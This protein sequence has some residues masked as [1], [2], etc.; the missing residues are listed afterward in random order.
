MWLARAF[1]GKLWL[2]PGTGPVMQPKGSPSQNGAGIA[3]GTSRIMSGDIILTVSEG[4][5][6]QKMGVFPLTHHFWGDFD[7]V[8]MMRP[9]CAFLLAPDTSQFRGVLFWGQLLGQQRGGRET[10]GTLRYP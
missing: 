6:S 10:A 7:H 2:E 9:V 8:R 4:Y 5:Q 1:S 3:L